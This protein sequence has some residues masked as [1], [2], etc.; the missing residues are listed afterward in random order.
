[1]GAMLRSNRHAQQAKDVAMQFATAMDQFVSLSTD[2]AREMEYD[3]FS[4][5]LASARETRGKAKPRCRFHPDRGGS[6]TK[7]PLESTASG[8]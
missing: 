5:R 8:V 1:M 7:P 4:T 6:L 3:E 2:M